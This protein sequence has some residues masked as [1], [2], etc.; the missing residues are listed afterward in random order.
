MSGSKLWTYYNSSHTVVAMVTPTYM[1][2][3]IIY[4]LA[5]F[6]GIPTIY[7]FADDNKSNKKFICSSV[8]N[9]DPTMCVLST[10]YTTVHCTLP[11][12]RFQAVDGNKPHDSS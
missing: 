11:V 6:V 7:E 8:N 9:A 10:L 2:I 1:V 4:T 3:Y 12:S 5:S